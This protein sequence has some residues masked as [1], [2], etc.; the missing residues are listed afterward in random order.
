MR[1]RYSFSARKRTR[2]MARDNKHKVAFPKLVLE[3]V[4]IS[5]VI[6]EVLDARFP[7]ETRNSEL[8]NAIKEKGKKI[9][10]VLNKSDM[11]DV[12][13]IKKKIELLD[14]Y[15]FV[16]VSC[17][18]RKGAGDLR[19]R[20]KIEV[21]DIA[22][23]SENFHRKQVGIIGYPNTGKSSIINLLT[24]R[25]SAKTAAEA[26]YTKGIQKIKLAKDIL[27]LDT[28]GVI[29]DKEDST[30]NKKD[31][32]KHTQIGVRTYDRVKSPDMVVY[33]LMK[34]FPDVIEKFYGFDVKGDSEALIEKLGRKRGILRRGNEVDVDR[35][36]R[37]ILKDWQDGKIRI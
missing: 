10:Y 23:K 5:D 32:T 11:V 13:K 8:E 14:L 16:F 19:D 20:I 12:D 34:K 18:S 24:G 28:P 7:E 4:R 15:P 27:I 35:T 36:A 29:P 22:G 31:L 2:V 26:G 33:E 6:L 25:S 17:L 1:V 21:K 3:V 30:K 37:S 9:I